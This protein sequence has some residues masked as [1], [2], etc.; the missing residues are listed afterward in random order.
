M[1]ADSFLLPPMPAPLVDLQAMPETQ[2]SME[3]NWAGLDAA[4][5]EGVQMFLSA[6]PTLV[7]AAKCEV[8]GEDEIM[9]SDPVHCR[10]GA[11]ILFFV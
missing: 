9:E 10:V 7:M 5:V 6:M 11:S 2:R 1:V 4:A 8:D 3:L